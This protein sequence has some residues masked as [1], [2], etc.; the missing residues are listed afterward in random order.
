MFV[1]S[2][3]SHA[4]TAETGLFKNTPMFNIMLDTTDVIF[5]TSVCTSATLGLT[6]TVLLVFEIVTLLY[7]IAYVSRRYTFVV[8]FARSQ[9]IFFSAIWNR[10]SQNSKLLWHISHSFISYN[11]GCT[12][13]LFWFSIQQINHQINHPVRNK[14]TNRNTCFKGARLTIQI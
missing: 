4:H 12:E 7:T 8:I 2:S 5:N 6:V 14:I 13:I 9:I 11:Y 1:L 10:T 3:K